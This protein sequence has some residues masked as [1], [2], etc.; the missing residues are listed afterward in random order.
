MYRNWWMSV[1]VIHNEIE[2]L[3]TAFDE[4]IAF[5]CSICSFYD[6]LASTKQHTHCICLSMTH[7]IQRIE[8]TIMFVF[9]ERPV[10][11]HSYFRYCRLSVLCEHRSCHI[12]QYSDVL[13]IFFLLLTVLTFAFLFPFLHSRRVIPVP[14]KPC[15]RSRMQAIGRA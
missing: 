3:H 10:S 13:N 4:T 11:V 2:T 6:R 8:S 9:A 12:S 5:H 1:V 7:T 15:T 14:S